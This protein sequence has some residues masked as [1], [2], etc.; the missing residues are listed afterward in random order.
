MPWVRRCLKRSPRFP[1]Y[2]LT[3]ADARLLER[4]A[5][6]IV[7]FADERI[8]IVELGSGSGVKT[9]WILE[10]AVDAFGSVCYSPIDVSSAALDNCKAALEGIPGVGIQPEHATMWTGLRSALRKRRGNEP[11]LVLFLG[12]S[13]GNFSPPDAMQLLTDVRRELTSGDVL[14]LGADLVKPEHILI[15]AY[16][17]PAGVTAAFNRNLLGRMNRELDADF[18]LRAFTHAARFDP[19][20]PAWKC[21]CARN[22]RRRCISA[23][24]K[25]RS[26]SPLGKP[27]GP[28]RAINSLRI[29]YET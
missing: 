13:I 2:G 17:D 22:A 8:R 5:K 9:R 29:R 12:S 3:R 10:A 23:P 14:L 26:V 21:T 7:G 25:G 18:D 15:D 4:H 16:D 19:K 11:A 6:T 1:E 20:L 27:S 28:S 24:W